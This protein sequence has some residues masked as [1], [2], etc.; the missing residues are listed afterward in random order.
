MET[1][2][3]RTGARIER[4]VAI[5]AVIAWRIAVLTQLA[6]TEPALPVTTAFTD[7]NLTDVSRARMLPPPETLEQAF[8]LVATMGG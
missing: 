2:A 7:I 8:R 3:H 5:N 6:Q 1:I 4:A